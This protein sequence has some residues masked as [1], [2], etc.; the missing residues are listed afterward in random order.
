MG[1][2]RASADAVIVGARTAL[3]AGPE[4]LWT[5]EYTDPDAKLLFRE[6]RVDVLH[7][8]EYPR[9]SWLAAVADWRREQFSERPKCGQQ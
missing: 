5:P 7:K 2:L 6:Y 1:L 8:P 9:L 4:A 3:D